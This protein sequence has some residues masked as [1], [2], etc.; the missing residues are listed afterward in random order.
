MDRSMQKNKRPDGSWAPWQPQQAPQQ[1]S[2]PQQQ[3]AYDPGAAQAAAQTAQQ[4]WEQWQQSRGGGQQVMSDADDLDVDATEAV[5]A[6]LRRRPANSVNTVGRQPHRVDD[7]VNKPEEIQVWS[8]VSEALAAVPPR[9]PAGN[10]G[11]RCPGCRCY[12]CR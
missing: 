8:D 6:V 1:Y 10:L 12:G 2:P 5:A 11:R 3:Q 9:R 4:Q 7:E